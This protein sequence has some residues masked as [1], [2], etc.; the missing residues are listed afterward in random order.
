MA[1][2]TLNESPVH[3]IF[4]DSGGIGSLLLTW[5]RDVAPGPF[6]EDEQAVAEFD[7]VHHVDQ[8]PGKPSQ[9]TGEL[10]RAANRHC[11]MTA[12]RGHR[13]VVAITK[14]RGWL[15]VQPIV[16]APSAPAR[17]GNAPRAI[18]TLLK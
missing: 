3:L 17:S 16:D 12:N 4:G 6:Q 15:A 8:Q 7:Q 9:V 2:Q 14:R 5:P 1:G 10:E 13:A 18:R 11:T